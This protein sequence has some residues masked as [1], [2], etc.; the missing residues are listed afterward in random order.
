MS[1]AAS[2][3]GRPVLLMALDPTL[4]PMSGSGPV[5]AAVTAAGTTA[6]DAVGPTARQR[7]R[8]Y[9]A[10]VATGDKDRLDDRMALVTGAA[11]G[12]G[13]AVALTLGGL[14]CRVA[15]CDLEAPDETSRLLGE[16]GVRCHQA[17]LDVRDD[18]AVAAFVAASQ[19]ALG[20]LDIVVNNAGGG[21][22]SPFEG[23]SATPS[24][25]SCARTSPVPPR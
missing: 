6:V 9:T 20:G 19:S 3:R 7:W 24:T 25:P 2:E 14:G 13:Q 8:S 11:Q 10:V 18:E 4:T 12:I 22:A 17:T 23:L 16:R 5:A 15:I 1:T 21:F